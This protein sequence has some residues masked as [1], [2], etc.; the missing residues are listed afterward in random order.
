MTAIS[1]TTS[2]KFIAETSFQKYFWKN[3]SDEVTIFNTTMTL[4]FIVTTAFSS[5]NASLEN[6][7]AIVLGSLAAFPVVKIVDNLLLKSE[8]KK[9]ADFNLHNSKFTM[10][11]K[12]LYHLLQVYPLPAH[13]EDE[14]SIL[15]EKFNELQKFQS[16]FE[17]Q[18][19]IV[20]NR[21]IVV[22][23]EKY[24]M[25]DKA[26]KLTHSICTFTSSCI[27]LAGLLNKSHHSFTHIILG[28]L[29]Y[30]SAAK[31]PLPINLIAGA[32]LGVNFIDAMMNV[33]YKTSIYG[34]II[35]Y[36]YPVENTNISSQLYS[37]I[38]SKEEYIL[39]TN[40]DQLSLPQTTSF[41]YFSLPVL[42]AV[43][44]LSILGYVTFR[45][46]DKYQQ[47]NRSNEIAKE[48]SQKQKES[49]QRFHKAN[50]DYGFT[51]I[52]SASTCFN[53]P[54]RYLMIKYP[55]SSLKFFKS[56]ILTSARV[57]GYVA[58]SLFL[59]PTILTE[60]GRSYLRRNTMRIFTNF[61]GMGISLIGIGLPFL[62]SRAYALQMSALHLENSVNL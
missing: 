2:P 21:L 24:Y 52:L 41:S 47:K 12:Q 37:L 49:I 38:T 25:Y 62:G 61:T 50:A 23:H 48:S 28:V 11:I 57:V 20:A 13:S 31:S 33:A 15:K 9:F 51:E 42:S 53:D 3:S 46:Y 60:I 14:V 4:S 18:Q 8:Y 19:K 45:F 27:A 22:P 58:L 44:A 17:L 29:F 43:A 34:Q 26:I 6:L 32:G 1:S 59:I 10:I 56:L 16:I 7:D 5:I 54:N 55:L 30:T 39:P 40:V 36:L 35:N